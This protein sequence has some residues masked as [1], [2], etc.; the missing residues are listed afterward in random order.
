MLSNKLTEIAILRHCF[1]STAITLLLASTIIDFVTASLVA[2]F[3]RR[4]NMARFRDFIDAA[5][6]FRD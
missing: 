3:D 4:I 6:Q 2:A 5:S 1:R